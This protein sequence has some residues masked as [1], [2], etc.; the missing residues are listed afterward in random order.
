[1][2]AALRTLRSRATGTRALPYRVVLLCL[3]AAGVALLLGAAL[4]KTQN[5]ARGEVF[6]AAL[7]LAVA[8]IILFA[9]FL[10]SLIA[11]IGQPRVMGEVLAGLLLGP[12]L[13]GALPALLPQVFPNPPPGAAGH[14]EH[15]PFPPDVLQAI[16][17]AAD[18][19]LAF[20]M[21]LVGLELDPQMLRGR[22][23]KAVAVSGASV[24][25]PF[26][27]GVTTAFLIHQ[28]G[29]VAL[30]GEKGTLLPFAIFMGVAMS[31]TAFPVLARILIERRMVK[32]PVGALALAAAA[33]DDV[34]AWSLLA[35]AAAFANPLK[36]PIDALLIVLLA[37]AFTG[38]M[39]LLGRPLLARV[40]AA[41]DEAG[42]IPA[43]WLVTIFI[44]IMLSGF[45]AQ[46]VGIAAI[47]G[48]FLMGAI[49]PRRSDLTHDISRPIENFVVVVLLPLFF[50]SAGL[51]A[52]LGAVIARFDLYPLALLLI[53]V[54]I[55]G[56]WVGA[57]FGA[58][59]TG[60]ST[61]ESAAIGALMNT[62]GLT[63]LIVLTIG[64]NLGVIG[65]DLFSILVLMALVT[66]F[67]AGPAL[68]LIDRKGEFSAGAEEE[69]RATPRAD[70]HVVQAPIPER[71]ILVAPLSERNFDG[72]MT[73]A[74]ALATTDPP[75]ELILARLIQPS[76]IATGVAAQDREL[77]LA[78][79]DVHRRRDALMGRHVAARAIAFISPDVGADLVRLA[80]EEE[81]DLILVDGRRSIGGEGVPTGPVGV[82]LQQ[83]PCDVA[84][85]VEREH[86]P[87]FGPDRPVL[88]PFGGAEHDWAALE[89]AAW[90]ASEREAPLKLVGIADQSAPSR[91]A[92]RLLASASLVVQQFASIP[93]QPLL[94]APGRAGVIE[95]AEGAGL[96]VVGLS[97]RWRTEGLGPLRAQIAST[98]PAPTLFVRRG[99]R[100]GALAPRQDVT[101]FSWSRTGAS[102]LRTP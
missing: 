100:P 99:T 2:T 49:M 27:L 28:P 44:A 85:L 12:T 22:M 35:I 90:I 83:A 55:V 52:D 4:L 59:L 68:K 66:T 5:A 41:Y 40:S 53:A 54:A 92:S 3:I 63:E 71:S 29:N 75:H 30:V 97:D 32:R 74:D 8:G 20:Y 34:I 24:L 86:I 16:K 14:L 81:I 39:F 50:V 56:K 96:L 70:E 48:A 89:L 17:G 33:V 45:M 93:A 76:R 94:V 61:R 38:T 15:W 64:A 84:V 98:V 19:G 88:V 60:S 26:T 78:S 31:I 13:L 77:A 23:G 91:D 101:R 79:A 87:I 69:L 1:M 57:M 10:G 42:Q 37:A 36:Q 65:T 62:R 21:F 58:K 43:A 6:F 47:F 9:R 82:V 51:N 73:I 80:S 72:L 11:R 95:A 67:M 25:L 18:L 7:M 46:Q 102:T